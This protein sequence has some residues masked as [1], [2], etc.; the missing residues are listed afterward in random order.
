MKHQGSIVY[1]SDM[2]MHQFTHQAAPEKKFFAA[3][4]ETIDSVCV[5]DMLLVGDFNARVGS[6]GRQ[7]DVSM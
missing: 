3:L 5:D 1:E 6:S 4:Q 7:K 2:F